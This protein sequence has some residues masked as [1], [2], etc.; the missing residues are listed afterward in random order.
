M[1]EVD[2]ERIK[3]FVMR[4]GEVFKIMIFNEKLRRNG[5]YEGSIRI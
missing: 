1:I 3:L 4:D 2:L 5:K